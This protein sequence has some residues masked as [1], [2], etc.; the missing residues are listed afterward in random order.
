MEKVSPT[1]KNNPKSPSQRK[2]C[3]TLDKDIPKTIY[4]VH[5]RY[6]PLV[7]APVKNRGSSSSNIN[8]RL[9]YKDEKTV[10]TSAIQKKPG[11]ESNAAKKATKI[12]SKVQLPLHESC[13]VS[14]SHFISINI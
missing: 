13:Q 6:L 14:F 4:D 1:K 2:I 10:S 5:K 12:F 3:L 7:Q 8:Q 11:D 9:V